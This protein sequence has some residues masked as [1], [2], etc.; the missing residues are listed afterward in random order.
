MKKSKFL[1]GLFFMFLLLFPS[2]IK[3][4]LLPAEGN[5]KQNVGW[6][7]QAWKPIP[8]AQQ[9]EDFGKFRLAL[10]RGDADEVK[11]LVERY[12]LIKLLSTPVIDKKNKK[13]MPICVAVSKG[14]KA[15]VEYML[16]VDAMLGEVYCDGAQTP[17]GLAIEK[18]YADIALPLADFYAKSPSLEKSRRWHEREDL[19]INTAKSITDAHALRQLVPDFLQA[20][21]NPYKKITVVTEYEADAFYQAAKIK[22]QH[23]V[24]ALRDELKKQ[25]RSVVSQYNIWRCK[26]HWTLSWKIPG[27]SDEERKIELQKEKEEKIAKMKNSPEAKFLQKHGIEFLVGIKWIDD[28]YY[29][30]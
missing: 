5:N 18:G 17:L 24:I 3:G 25:G 28:E 10:E 6:S 9:V 8:F 16:S 26:D 20:G 21:E 7:P 1:L 12:P 2:P 15:V 19:M 22:N 11:R 23:F 13:M 30:Y 14:H 29:C 4:Q 27:V